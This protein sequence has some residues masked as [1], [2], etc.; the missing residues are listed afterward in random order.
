MNKKH[1]AGRVLA[2][3]GITGLAPAL[4]LA[5]ALPAGYVAGAFQLSPTAATV[6]R[7]EAH[8]ALLSAGWHVTQDE[9]VK[10]EA[11]LAADPENLAI[12][13]RLLSYYSQYMIPEPR[14]KHLL[15]LIEHHPEADVFNMNS[16]VTSATRDWTGMNTPENAERA[17]TLWVQQAERFS[18]NT[19]V[20][21]N[22]AV[23]LVAAEPRIS[24]DLVKRARTV[25]PNNPEWV[26]WLG[27]I[28]ARAVRS[29]FAGGRQTVSTAQNKDRD[30][31][32]AFRLPLPESQLLKS[33]LQTSTDAELVG[34]A[35]EALIYETSQLNGFGLV[36]ND[37]LTASAEFGK[38]LLSRARELDPQN[39]RWKN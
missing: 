23:A 35:G 25:E 8:R 6:P 15:W 1:L 36:G 27:S 14:S 9:A 31:R 26:N 38:S 7:A 22:A 37:E 33:E 39:P 4:I 13:S 18:T 32:F 5:I 24:L 20:L 3:R 34:A 17:R 28:Y 10:L 19:K 16:V 21:A 29:S 11:Q 30:A 12:R 2:R